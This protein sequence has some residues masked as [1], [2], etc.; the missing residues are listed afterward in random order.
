MR[1]LV[2][3]LASPGFLFPL[4][5]LAHA[6]RERGH[7]VSFVTDRSFHRLLERQGLESIE[8]RGGGPSFEVAGWADPTAMSVQIEHID[9][10]FEVFQP[11]LLIGQQ[12]TYGP[13]VVG[14]LRR[15][16]VALMGQ[17]VYLWQGSSGSRSLDSYAEAEKLRVARYRG[18]FR[19]HNRLRESYRLPPLPEEEQEAVHGDLFMLR[20]VPEWQD[21]FA[22]L[23]L[24][25][26][27]VGACLWEPAQEHEELDTWLERQMADDRAVVYVQHGRAFHLP[28]FWEALRDAC[29]HLNVA[30]VASLGRMDRSPGALPETFFARRHVPQ[31]RV[32]KI[33]RAVVSNANT[34]VTLGALEAGVP[35]LVLPGGAEQPDIAERCV[36]LG[37]ARLVPLDEAGEQR[38]REELERLLI[39]EML[40]SRA[41]ALQAAFARSPGFDCA[42]R[43]IETLGE[44]RG[45]VLRNV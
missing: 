27:L 40:R 31:Q 42:V 11:D 36:R 43:M 1:I 32:L 3:S 14:A 39:D 8:R 17:G 44:R 38:L 24:R 7:C 19:V 5:G 30:V 20:A 28:S 9:H 16:P 41:A 35:G 18:W 22:E 29:A 37:V 34:T 23:P 2:G 45:P 25:V 10:A 21:D 15:V 12:L 6:L 13:P 33:A 4:I 26:H